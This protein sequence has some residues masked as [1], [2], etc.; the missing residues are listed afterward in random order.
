MKLITVV[1]ARPQFVKAAALSR[2]IKDNPFFTE[3]IVHTGQHYDVEMS[4]FFFDELNIPK[5]YINLEIG[6]AS[7]AV[8]TAKMLIKLEKVFVAENPDCVVVYGDTNSTIAAAIAASKL[9]IKVAHIEAGLRSFNNKM[10][11]EINRIVTDKLSNYLFSPTKTA[12]QNLKNEGLSKNSF[13]VGDI[14]FD[15]VLHYTN[16]LTDIKIELPKKFYL[17]TVHRPVNTNDENKL[18][19][20][21]KAFSKL[22]KPI[23]LPLHPRTKKYIDLYKIDLKNI[24]VKK[25]FSYMQMLKALTL[26]Q[27]VFTDSGGLQKEAYFLKKQC[28]TLRNE[29][30]WIE[31]LH[32]NW[33][34][35]CGSDCLKILQATE[36]S[37]K[38]NI[39][40]EN[41]G[42]GTTAK[43]ILEILKNH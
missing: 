27:K 18:K 30:E 15:S 29:T 19:S 25:P 21:F 31:T 16:L 24:I 22:D 6:S 41:F 34:C 14:M 43:Q 33:N 28:I 38:N 20:I 42:Y 39:T 37:T 9:N 32:D 7:H 40:Q 1:G 12:M 11:E 4:Q 2:E 26:C 8:Q 35:L 36:K 3:L 23:V 5:P 10:P 13:F 17:A